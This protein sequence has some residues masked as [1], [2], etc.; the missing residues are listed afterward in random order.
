ML[1]RPDQRI[2]GQPI[3]KIR[4][5]LRQVRGA[6]DL[7]YRVSRYC[8][9]GPQK[10]A[11]VIAA[12][13]ASGYVKAAA[14]FPNTWTLTLE[15]ASLAHA[16]ARRIR[17]R[18]AERTLAALLPRAER[19]GKDDYFLY[20]VERMGVFGSYLSDAEFLG[21]LDIAIRMM[22]K[23][24][25][26]TRREQLFADRV[27]AAQAAGRRFGNFSQELEWP[28]RETLMFLRTHS[29]I[30]SFHD[31]DDD[32]IL[33]RVP[34]RWVYSHRTGILRRPRLVQPSRASDIPR[35]ST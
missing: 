5:V 4:Q 20:R 26:Q 34:I 18:T 32:R 27:E 29:P 16:A 17:R 6:T 10:A 13:E 7:T 25:D 1:I 28:L 15:G 31:L 11:V 8:H 3:L 30:I 12:L 23:E 21:D 9:I 2:A 19:V 22:P 24:R 14:S 33:R 35:S